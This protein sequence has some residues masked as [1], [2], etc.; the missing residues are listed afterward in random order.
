VSEPEKQAAE[1]SGSETESS[2]DSEEEV[3]WSAMLKNAEANRERLGLDDVSDG[4]SSEDE[5]GNKVH[6]KKD[7]NGITTQD[8]MNRMATN[9]LMGYDEFGRPL[10]HNGAMMSGKS[11]NRA[12]LFGMDGGKRNTKKG[13]NNKGAGRKDRSGRSGGRRAKKGG[14]NMAL[15][16]F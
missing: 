9:Q 15:L 7:Q 8:L 1:E 12:M 6:K 2:E 10:R 5:E 4:V 13:S 3:D 11:K 14:A 16:G